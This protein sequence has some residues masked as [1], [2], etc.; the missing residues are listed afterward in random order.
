MSPRKSVANSEDLQQ[1][2]EG[3]YL[4]EDQLTQTVSFV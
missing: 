3:M 2:F 1:N 4:S